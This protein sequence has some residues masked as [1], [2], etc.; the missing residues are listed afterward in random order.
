MGAKRDG[1]HKSMARI[2]LKLR[3]S[4]FFVPLRR[5]EEIRSV[6]LILV[7]TGLRYTPIA[8]LG[9]LRREA[10]PPQGD[11]SPVG[12]YTYEVRSEAPKRAKGSGT[13]KGFL[14]V[15]RSAART[16]G[17]DPRTRIRW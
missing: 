11:R 1:L 5:K 16:R 6:L 15:A 10:E 2:Y 14:K 3:W 7:S 13:A 8:A 9:K 4:I 12:T 17:K